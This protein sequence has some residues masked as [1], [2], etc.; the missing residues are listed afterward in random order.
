M[1]RESNVM[2]SQF[3]FLFFAFFGSAVE[4]CAGSAP[5]RVLNVRLVLDGEEPQPLLRVK[6]YNRAVKTVENDEA[7]VVIVQVVKCVKGTS[8]AHSRHSQ[9]KTLFYTKLSKNLNLLI[10]KREAVKNS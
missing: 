8:L 10:S 3:F 4:T 5:L 2:F 9:S 7:L 1:A 6:S